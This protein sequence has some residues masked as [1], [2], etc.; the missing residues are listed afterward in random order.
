[1]IQKDICSIKQALHSVASTAPKGLE[2]SA[3]L[4]QR[5]A[6]RA[7]EAEDEKHSAPQ[8]QK[9]ARSTLNQTLHSAQGHLAAK[10]CM[11]RCLFSQLRHRAVIF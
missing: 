6:E 11:K 7:G 10:F 5:A 1:M 8:K 4:P 3:P 9:V 2:S